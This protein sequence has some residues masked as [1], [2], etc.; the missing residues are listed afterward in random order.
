MTDNRATG[1]PREVTGRMVLLCLVAFFAIVFTVNMVM[2]RAAT[3]TFGGVETESAY[4]VGLLFKNEIAAA[5]AQENLHWQVDGKVARER[6]GQAKVEIAVRDR[7]GLAPAGIVVDALLAHPADVRHD[8]RLALTQTGSGVFRAFDD[9]EPG[10]WNLVIS[11]YRGD[12]RVFLSR[13][14]VILR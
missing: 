7:N 10:Q 6:D 4:R 2:L 5:R 14:R 1:K 12:E 8:R 3:S 11:V 9:A 13:S